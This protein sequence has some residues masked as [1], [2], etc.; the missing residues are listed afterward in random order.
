[1]SG[2]RPPRRGVVLT[3]DKTYVKGSKT[4][5]IKG[6]FKRILLYGIPLLLLA[7]GVKMLDDEARVL[8]FE[9]NGTESTN[10]RFYLFTGEKERA[11]DVEE[12]DHIR[13]TWGYQLRQGS[14]ILELYFPGDVPPRTIDEPQLI[15]FVSPADG[16]IKSKVIGQ[17]ARGNF[18]LRWEIP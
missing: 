7:V 12:G 3:A 8:W 16:R 18:T 6:D 17:R 1:M 15:D 11:F 14:L 2:G 13:I 4:V 9:K 10:A 5:K